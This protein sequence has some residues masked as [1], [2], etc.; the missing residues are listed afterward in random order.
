MLANEQDRLGAVEAFVAVGRRLSF[1]AA[2][3]D[4]GIS[5]SALSRRITRLEERLNCRLLQRS[6]RH[7]SFTEAGL[8]VHESCRDLM[9]RADAAVAA[10]SEHVDEPSGLLRVR[11]P[12]TYGLRRIAP[13]LASF[14]ATHPRIRIELT[15]E[16]GAH[17]PAGT[18]DDVSLRIGMIE[19]G[20]FVA[21]RLEPV[22][23]MLCASTR[24]LSRRRAPR[25]PEDL[26]GHGCLQYR[27]A[28]NAGHW[29]LSRGNRSFDF[30]FPGVFASNDIEAV[31]ALVLGDRSI[32]LL[33]SALIRDELAAG[34]LQRV[35][36]EWS[37][38]RYWVHLVYPRARLLPKRTRAFVDFLQQAIGAD[39][40]A[41]SRPDGAR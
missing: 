3:R 40:L 35:L 11:S 24:Y 29:R 16:D 15:L 8:Q 13:L 22:G 18:M 9:A 23:W 36:P 34:R 28:G 27:P 32:A 14:M 12:V 25:A 21:R 4:L 26:A 17:D 2:A 1:A 10:L 20:D 31:L 5:A 37:G 41:E 33:P 38:P 39:P 19:R 7:V 6:T 30:D